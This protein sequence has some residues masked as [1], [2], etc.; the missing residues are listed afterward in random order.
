MPHAPGV[1]CPA[2]R[3]YGLGIARSYAVQEPVSGGGK[4]RGQIWHVQ[5]H[6]P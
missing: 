2:A 1:A 5:G 3:A 6:W 4:A